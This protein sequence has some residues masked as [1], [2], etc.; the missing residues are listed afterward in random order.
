[1]EEQECCKGCKWYHTEVKLSNSDLVEEDIFGCSNPFIDSEWCLEPHRPNIKGIHYE[2]KEE[3][4]SI[5][6]HLKVL[7]VIGAVAE[8]VERALDTTEV[9]MKKRRQEDVNKINRLP[10]R[11][12]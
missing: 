1:M 5:V 10:L 11:H 4:P 7:N 3:I 12:R 8:S 9:Q 6:D 2:P